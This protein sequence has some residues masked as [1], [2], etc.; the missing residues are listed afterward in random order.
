MDAKRLKAAFAPRKEITKGQLE[1]LEE[2]YRTSDGSSMR[3]PRLI[4]A[5]LNEV[6]HTPETLRGALAEYETCKDQDQ[7]MWLK[8]KITYVLPVND[9][10]TEAKALNAKRREVQNTMDILYTSRTKQAPEVPL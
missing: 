4:E 5:G 9:H 1:Q 7:R 8:Y 6:C 10:H 3:V 2:I